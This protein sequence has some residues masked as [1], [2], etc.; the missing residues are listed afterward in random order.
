MTTSV[1]KKLKGKTSVPTYIK[2]DSLQDWTGFEEVGPLPDAWELVRECRFSASHP[3]H[4]I[5]N[6]EWGPAHLGLKLY[7]KRIC[8]KESTDE[9]Q[10]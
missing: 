6:S 8:K 5:R 1:L 4:R 10:H 7:F 3:H 2:W 9:Q